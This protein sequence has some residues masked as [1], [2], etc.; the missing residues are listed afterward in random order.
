[1][2]ETIASKLFD[3]AT[4]LFDLNS[5]IKQAKIDEKKRISDFLKNISEALDQLATN[6]EQGKD[7][8]TQCGELDTYV[9]YLIQAL[10]KHLPE[11]TISE[12]SHQLSSATLTRGLMGEMYG[13]EKTSNIQYIRESVGKFRALSKVI[14]L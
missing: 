2:I 8:S 12:F 9:K 10:K 14:V 3:F 13:A 7:M 6:A 11:E 5:V 4:K 1:M